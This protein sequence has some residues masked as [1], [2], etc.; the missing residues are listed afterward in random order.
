MG[1]TISSVGSDNAVAL[2]VKDVNTAIEL[3]LK[4]DSVHNPETIALSLM[5]HI[6]NVQLI[7]PLLEKVCLH[8]SF[9][10]IFMFSFSILKF[11]M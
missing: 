1:N 7:K 5:P 8:R 3:L 2:A 9:L 4:Q 11:Y 6:K 10:M